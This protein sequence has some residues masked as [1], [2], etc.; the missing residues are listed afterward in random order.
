M[1]K[2]R[3]I[4]NR[5]IVQ[6]SGISRITPLDK[7]DLDYKLFKFRENRKRVIDNKTFKNEEYD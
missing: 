5:M 7:S 6:W 3:L 2:A 4:R 1:N